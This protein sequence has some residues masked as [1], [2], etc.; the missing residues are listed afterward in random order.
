MKIMWGLAALAALLGPGPV[1]ASEADD[2]SRLLRDNSWK[3]ETSATGLSGPGAAR[4]VAWSREA[5]FFLLGENHDSA[6]IAR[7]ATGVA[8][9]LGP[10]G[11]RHTVVEADPLVTDH[12]VRLLK[13]GGMPAFA[14][15]LATDQRQRAVPFFAWREEADF[16]VA[17]L[18]NGPVWGVD[19][20][21][22]AAA[23]VHLDAIAAQTR[24]RSARTMAQAMAAEARADVIGWLAKVDRARIVALRDAIPARDAAA[25][26]IAD[27]LV[28]SAA[29][30]SPFS[31][32]Q[33]SWHRANLARETLMKR[34]FLGYYDAVAKRGGPPPRVLF[35]F[36]A[37]HLQRGLSETNVP[38]LGNFLAEL[39]LARYDRP[40][41]NLR[42]MCGPGA[43]Q[44]TFD[45]SVQ[46]CADEFAP[47][48]P[49]LGAALSPE[50]A[51]VFDL[52]PL[53][54]KPRLWRDW[55]AEAK[56]LVWTYDAVV[57]IRGGGAA[58]FIAPPPK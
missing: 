40:V 45:G 11:F 51:T 46:S 26:R 38:S 56:R 58:T 31:G 30:Y 5:Q 28:Q 27:L 43:E 21:F 4:I 36:G 25:R 52:R 3:V 54:D 10:V 42:V 13:Q 9:A 35:K 23:H 19:Q 44:V 24:D 32:G 47:L 20:S 1:A 17:A 39:A 6:G 48:A 57:V 55:P 41:F 15:W 34:S 2:L 37:W 14:N 33:G 12:M 53:R 18:A 16:A 29:I 22:L 7:F 49:A 50:G 8:K